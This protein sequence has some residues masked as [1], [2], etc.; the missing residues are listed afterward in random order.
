MENGP[1]Y[2]IY[3]VPP[4]ES[5]L[6]RFGSSILGYDCYTGDAVGPA[7]K[8]AGEAAIWRGLTGEARRYGFHATLKAPFFLS[9]SCTELQLIKAVQDFAD[10]GHDIPSIPPFIQL[11]SGF[12]AIVS[13]K[14][15]PT[16]DALAAHCTTIFDPFRA[17]MSRQERARRMASGLTCDQIENLDRWGYPY[18]FNDFRFHLTLTGRLTV[19]LQESIITLL[20][21]RFEQQCGYRAISIDRLALLKQDNS[22]SAFQVLSC[23]SLR[24]QC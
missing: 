1:R 24:G 5:N 13:R 7:D 12:A 15:E 2:A 14:P 19:D 6:Y 11:L 9:P 18:L 20:R 8:F 10:F 23:A 17:P 16:V 4:A 3:F 21:R 22:R